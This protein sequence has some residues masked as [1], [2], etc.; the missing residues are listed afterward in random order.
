MESSQ[1]NRYDSIVPHDM[2]TD[3]LGDVN[4][5]KERRKEIG[6]CDEQP[7]NRRDPV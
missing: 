5:K 2:G 7:V 6:S 1:H 4:D 3:I